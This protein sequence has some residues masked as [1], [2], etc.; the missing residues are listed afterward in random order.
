M[1][2][3]QENSE[4]DCD[5]FPFTRYIETPI[6]RDPKDIRAYLSSVLMVDPVRSRCHRTATAENPH[7]LLAYPSILD[8]DAEKRHKAIDD[9]FL[10]EFDL[11][12]TFFFAGAGGSGTE[13]LNT[14]PVVYAGF[15]EDGDM[16]GVYSIR[17]DT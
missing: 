1:E 15:T 6:S 12:D 8:E 14:Y 2:S 9:A 4:Q 7:V 13:P 17:V 3:I 11:K 16:L 5:Y 10:Q